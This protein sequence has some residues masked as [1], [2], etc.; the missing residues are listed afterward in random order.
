MNCLKGSVT[1][2]MIRKLKSILDEVIYIFCNYFIC[3]IPIWGI[4]KI[5]YQMLGMKIGKGSRILMKT[6]VVHPWKIVIG[7]KTYV[8]EYCFLDGRGGISIGENVTIAIFSKLI[9][10]YHNIDD[11]SFSYLEEPIIIEDNSAVFTNVTVLPGVHIREGCIVTAGAV[12]KR[13]EYKEF[14]VYGGNPIK[15]IRDRKVKKFDI[16]GSWKPLFR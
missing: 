3:Y 6:I 10:G 9:T 11:E 4:R 15:H 14:C 16:S 13:G 1:R 5:L 7:K 12:V 2:E 8:N